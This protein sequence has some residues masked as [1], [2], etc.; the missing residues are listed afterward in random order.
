M[1]CAP[2]TQR[3][4]TMEIHMHLDVEAYYVR[5]AAAYLLQDAFDESRARALA[6]ICNYYEDLKCKPNSAI[7][8]IEQRGELGAA[9]ASL[10]NVDL[11]L[12]LQL[13]LLNNPERENVIRKVGRP[14]SKPG[15]KDQ[16][17][18]MYFHLHRAL[19][20]KVWKVPKNERSGLPPRH[21]AAEKAQEICKYLYPNRLRPRW[22][23]STLIKAAS[24]Q[25][26]KAIKSVLARSSVRLTEA[27]IQEI[28]RKTVTKKADFPGTVNRAVL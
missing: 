13:F 4:Q 23:A 11:P 16:V 28:L 21:F 12:E 7:L 19:K 18:M 27:D 9:I 10:G 22:D 20:E 17:F 8:T 25:R 3:T 24:T 26:G 2:A 5:H 6:C 15:Q 14:K 1:C